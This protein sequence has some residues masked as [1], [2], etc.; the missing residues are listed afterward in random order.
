M[1]KGMFFKKGA[2]IRHTAKGTTGVVIDWGVL[3]NGY[4]R[5][6]LSNEENADSLRVWTQEGTIE[7]WPAGD[8]KLTNERGR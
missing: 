3:G 5:F 1:E 4:R 2:I 7:V 6:M 8:V